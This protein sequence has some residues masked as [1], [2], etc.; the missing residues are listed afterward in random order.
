MHQLKADLL[1]RDAAL[2]SPA[3]MDKS[4]CKLLFGNKTSPMLS[5][6]LLQLY[7][8]PYML[9]LTAC[10]LF[11]LVGQFRNDGLGHERHLGKKVG[12]RLGRLQPCVCPRRRPNPQQA[13]AHLCMI[14]GQTV[15]YVIM[16]NATAGCSMPD[17]TAHWAPAVAVQ[18]GT[19]ETSDCWWRF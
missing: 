10:P 7:Q 16:S 15:Q 4:R 18:A 8:S 17:G 5:T 13:L 6:F 3:K 19:I 11:S 12:L 9:D 2:L 14:A 1:I